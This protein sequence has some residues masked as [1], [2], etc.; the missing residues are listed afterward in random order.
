MAKDLYR[1][2][3]L[4]MATSAHSFIQLMGFGTLKKQ[5]D[6]SLFH[7]IGYDVASKS[8]HNHSPSTRCS[9]LQ[10]VL[11]GCWPEL[12]ETILTKLKLYRDSN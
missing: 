4:V 7:I 5:D 11:S 2:G 1:A 3:G 10:P 12:A 8:I 9:T 6:R